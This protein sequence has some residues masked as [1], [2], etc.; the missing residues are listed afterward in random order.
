MIL[1]LGG[2]F[3]DKAATIDR[4]RTNYLALP[5]SVKARLV[6]ENDDVCWH[7]HDL[8]PVCEELN[9]P[10]VLDFHHHNILFDPSQLRE[11]THDIRAL[12]P[13]IA[14]TW[15]RKNITQ[16]MH[17][18]ES[19]PQA[20]T[21]KQRRKHS[22]RVKTLPPCDSGMDL[23]IEAKDK[24]QAVFEVMKVFRLEGFERLGDIV[25]YR[26]DDENR[27]MTKKA[28]KTRR[29]RGKMGDE[30]LVEMDEQ[31]ECPEVVNEVVLEEEAA[32]GGPD[33]RVYWPPGMEEWLRP[34][35]RVVVKKDNGGKPAP[36]K[37]AAKAKAKAKAGAETPSQTAVN[38]EADDADNVKPRPAKRAVS[39]K[40][41][42]AKDV[43]APSTSDGEDDALSDFSTHEADPKP[44][45]R[46]TKVPARQSK[47]VQRVSYAED[48][49]DERAEK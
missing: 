33:G 3:G 23:M 14:A 21:P 35:K 48:S 41:K 44:K 9:I 1:H 12:F 27:P 13:R 24:E 34:K 10:L 15:A 39:A 26:R 16:K 38:A 2:A 32:M 47:R 45:P 22:P 42:M 28:A 46:P 19:E 8:L 20:L 37:K 40:K 18:S 11:G 43:P 4:F 7:V 17:Y 5:D 29:K 36:A 31:I 6:L 49:D 25:P 30:E